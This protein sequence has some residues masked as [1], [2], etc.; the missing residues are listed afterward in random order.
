MPIQDRRVIHMVILCGTDDI[1][2][3]GVTNVCKSFQPASCIPQTLAKQSLQSFRF[4]FFL[5]VV[6]KTPWGL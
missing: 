1:Q 2:W 3:G 4:F 5:L 6:W